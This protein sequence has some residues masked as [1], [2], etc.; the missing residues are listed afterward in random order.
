MVIVTE[1]SSN[2]PNQYCNTI[3][4]DCQY[5]NDR[6][7]NV[8]KICLDKT[9]YLIS[10]FFKLRVMIQKECF[11]WLDFWISKIFICPTTN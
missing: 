7:T 10:I 2:L 6:Y 11:L 3:W 5:K 8:G 9:H 4:G 1:F